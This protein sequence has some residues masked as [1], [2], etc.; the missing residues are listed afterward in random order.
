MGRYGP[1]GCYYRV[2]VIC[3]YLL[4]VQPII[5][6]SQQLEIPQRTKQ[7]L[8]SPPASPPVGWEPVTEE[9]PCV[10]YSLVTALASLQLPGEIAMSNR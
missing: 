2:V 3:C 8:I 4:S 1:W 10:D 6:G 5:L 7:F 9:S